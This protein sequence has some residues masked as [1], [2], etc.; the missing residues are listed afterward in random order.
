MRATASRFQFVLAV[1]GARH[2]D[3]FRRLSL[4]SLLTSGNL[5]GFAPYQAELDIY[6]TPQD[7]GTVAALAG[8]AVLAGF[9][10]V[11]VTQANVDERAIA[12]HSMRYAIMNA[13]HSVAIER[14]AATDATLVFLAPDA[15]FADGT[16]AHA[17]ELVFDG[18]RVVMLPG[19]RSSTRMADELAARYNPQG[20][21]G[22]RVSPRELVALLM[23]CPHEQSKWRYWGAEQLTSWPSHLYFSVSH[24]GFVMRGFHHHPIALRPRNWNVRTA[25]TI[26]DAWL[27]AAVPDAKMWHLIT[28]TDDGFVVDV[29][30]G[31]DQQYPASVRTDPE[32][33]VAA[34]ARCNSDKHQ[35]SLARE[36]VFVHA[37][38]LSAQWYTVAAQAGE[39]VDRI[40]AAA[41]APGTGVE[42]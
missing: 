1:W 29:G 6:T 2:I 36:N 3:L 28:D 5:L 19:A 8:L 9:M 40:I 25:G 11:R 35:R 32:D 39:V 31:P 10:D 20:R 26:D 38:P 18:K 30:T 4:P 23:S 22:M 17:R 13:M 37:G 14:A 12:N 41:D 15:V 7:H 27:T 21:L 24:E 33:Y 34:W 42:A 16:L